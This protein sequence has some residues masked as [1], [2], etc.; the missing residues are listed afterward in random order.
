MPGITEMPAIDVDVCSGW[1]ENDLDLYQAL[2]FYLAKTQVDRRKWWSIWSKFTK[3]RPWK[4]NMGPNMR[5]VRKAPSPHL[6][7]FAQPSPLRNTPTKDV[8]DVREVIAEANV[9]R[10]RFESPVMNFFPSFNDFLDHVDDHGQDIM[11]KIERYEDIFIRTQIFHM[12]PYVFVAQADGTVTLVNA[13]YWWGTGAFDATTDGKTTA[14]LTALVPQI[15]GHL[16]MAAINHAMNIAETDLRI[17][18]FSGSGLPSGNS[19]PLDQKFCVVTSSEA[20]NQ[21]VFDPWVLAQKNCSLNIVTEQFKGDLWGKATCMLEDLPLRMATDAEFHAPELRVESDEEHIYND[22]DTEPNDN[23]TSLTESPIEISWFVGGNGYESIDVG[24]PP[25]KFTGDSPP[26]EF[27]GMWWNGAV[28]LT[29]NFLVPCANSE[30]GEILYEANTYGEHLKFVS[31]LAL[32][33]VP[34][35][36]RNV[37]PILHLRRRGA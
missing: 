25:A 37:I 36:R 17:V 6:R 26:Q 24:P 28:K 9:Y 27:P 23:Y 10:H 31:Q 33:C 8:M 4:P 2:P 3:K 35:N 22:E 32:G 7:Q 20:W 13:P 19:K 30:T 21:F 1:T 5:L 16:S 15:T 18:P 34:K 29:K 12:S 11:E 14:F